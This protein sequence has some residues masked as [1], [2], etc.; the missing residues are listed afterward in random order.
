MLSQYLLLCNILLNVCTWATS[1]NKIDV[2][3][4]FCRCDILVREHRNKQY[5]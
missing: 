5:I 1:V 4:Y 3:S 2:D